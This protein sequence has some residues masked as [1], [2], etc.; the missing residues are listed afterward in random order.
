MERTSGEILARLGTF[1]K[2][3]GMFTDKMDKLGRSL[4]AT[5]KDYEDLTTTRRRQLERELDKI[6][7]LRRNTGDPVDAAPPTLALEA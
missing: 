4:D 1:Q 6:E 3:W 5:R 2:Q 7:D